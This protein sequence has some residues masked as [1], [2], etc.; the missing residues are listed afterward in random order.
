[1]T[2]STRRPSE[3]LL[4]L[5]LVVLA[6]ILQALTG[7]FDA[8]TGLAY[9]GLRVFFDA[10]RGVSTSRQREHAHE[11]AG[12]G[13]AT[14]FRAHSRS[15]EHSRAPCK[16]ERFS[17]SLAEPLGSF[18]RGLLTLERNG[19]G[20]MVFVTLMDQT[21]YEASA[22]RRTKGQCAF[23]GNYCNDSRLDEAMQ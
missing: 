6:G 5:L 20:A 3:A 7:S 18:E 22:A 21:I 16:G 11:G 8:L 10:V 12:A 13:P 14:N 15:I 1:M 19:Y 4:L 17:G 9:R 2:E 23:R